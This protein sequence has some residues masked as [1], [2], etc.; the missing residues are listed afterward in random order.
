MHNSWCQRKL[1]PGMYFY[2]CHFDRST[3]LLLVWRSTG[4][5]AC[6]LQFMDFAL[7]ALSLYLSAVYP[8]ITQTSTLK[9]A[10][11]LHVCSCVSPS[12]TNTHSNKHRWCISK[13]IQP[14]TSVNSCCI[15]SESAIYRIPFSCMFKIKKNA[16]SMFPY[17]K[18][19]THMH[20]Q[21][22]TIESMHWASL[23]SNCMKKKRNNALKMVTHCITILCCF[24]LLSSMAGGF[25]LVHQCILAN[26]FVVIFNFGYTIIYSSHWIVYY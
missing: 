1:A 4:V 23:R 16:K 2:C 20:N 17:R 11:A 21:R 24:F 18:T 7:N 9:Y 10:M 14:K 13:R 6:L 25:V 19:H 15:Y 5:Y 26:F 8:C 12:H 3:L 22:D